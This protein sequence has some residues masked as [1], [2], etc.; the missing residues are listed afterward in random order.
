MDTFAPDQLTHPTAGLLPRQRSAADLDFHRTVSRKLVHKAA[1]SEVFLTDS[2]RATA[3]SYL[4]AAQWPR[5]HAVFQPGPGGTADSMVIIETV[6]QAT[7]FTFHEYYGVPLELPFVAKSFDFELTDDQ[8]AR[9]S[10]GAPQE[11]TLDLV[12]DMPAERRAGRRMPF[13]THTVV[14]AGAGRPCARVTIGGE[15]L[16]PA[17]YRRLRAARPAEP[18]LPAEDGGAVAAT[19]A[20]VG[21]RRPDD[22]VLLA[23]QPGD[24]ARWRLR[25]DQGHPT[26]FDHGSDHVQ[27]VLLLEALRQSGLLADGPAR[28]ALAEVLTGL[29]VEFHA[30]GEFGTPILLDARATGGEPGTRTVR[31]TAAQAGRP[32]A[33]ADLVF[34]PA[35]L[36]GGPT[37]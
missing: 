3:D 1:V 8:A 18:G 6:R 29:R 33:Q 27:A 24:D 28:G 13:R 17:L 5:D 7:M 31:A 35:A 32:I 10:F 15:I 14:H 22:V 30:Y 36:P 2:A 9:G 4:L 37:S 20:Q 19:P 26:F 34:R 12:V 21:R 23:A 25:V 11:V 16:D